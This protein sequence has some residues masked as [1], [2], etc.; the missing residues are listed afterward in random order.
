MF[1]ENLDNSNEVEPE[2]GCDQTLL[3]GVEVTPEKL[4]KV[5][6]W[7]AT[8]QKT[9]DINNK[10]KSNGTEKYL[11]SKDSVLRRMNLLHAV[12]ETSQRRKRGKKKN[13][14]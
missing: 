14:L 6:N 10:L 13:Y 3:S 12:T 5:Y 11:I 2:I 4:E 8:D 7:N 9:N 1:S